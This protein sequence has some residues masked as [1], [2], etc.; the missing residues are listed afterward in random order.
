MPEVII[1]T[2]PCHCEEHS[3]EAIPRAECGYNSG[4]SHLTVRFAA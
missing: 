4:E 1:T 2:T 3:D